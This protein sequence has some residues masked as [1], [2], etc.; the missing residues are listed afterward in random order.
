MESLVTNMESTNSNGWLAL[1]S[2]DTVDRL[3]ELISDY[4]WLEGIVADMAGYLER[5]GEVIGMFSDALRI[6]DENTVHYMIE[7]QKEELEKAKQML[8]EKDKELAKALAEI[9]RL[10][11]EVRK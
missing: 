1:L 4:P 10:K 7:Q 3:D 2:T 9:D 6:L 11:S 5:P 8:A